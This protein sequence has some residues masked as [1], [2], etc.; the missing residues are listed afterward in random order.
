MI[1]FVIGTGRVLADYC[2]ILESPYNIFVG[3]EQKFKF[4][5]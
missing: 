4:E 1:N 5:F 3:I 2:F